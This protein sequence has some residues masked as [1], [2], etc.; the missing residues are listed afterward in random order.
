[1]KKVLISALI[2]LLGMTSCDEFSESNPTPQLKGTLFQKLNE[3]ETESINEF[4]P[5]FNSLGVVSQIKIESV[6]A[7]GI[8]FR[9]YS[10]S[11]TYFN[12]T[13][14]DLSTKEFQVSYIQ[15][16]YRIKDSDLDFDLVF[17]SDFALNS[18]VKNNL[19]NMAEIEDLFPLY[20]FMIN[21]FFNP[22]AREDLVE[23]SIA[24]FKNNTAE[25]CRRAVG[26]GFHWNKSDADYFC[27][28]DKEKI[29]SEHPGWTTTGVSTSCVT[30][31]HF[32]ACTAYF[33]EECKE[34]E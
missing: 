10:N 23:S 5:E 24:T 32:C 18:V 17:N 30:D 33:Y 1:M 12:G 9:V 11:K 25:L 4:S 7:D 16:N 2:V 13:Q 21:E 26:V 8:F 15:G 31:E 27:E 3:L 20:S 14:V 22:N 29:L 6:D 34:D 28:A 19:S